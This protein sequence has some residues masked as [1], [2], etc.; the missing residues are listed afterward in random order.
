MIKSRGIT[1]MC[2][3]LLL[4]AVSVPA[5]A[6]NSAVEELTR[7]MPDQTMLFVATSGHDALADDCAKTILG[8]LC[9]DP[10]VQTFV[11]T[12]KTELL[13][14]LGR[15]E[16]EEAPEVVNMILQYAEL[17]STRPIMI[18]LAGVEVEEGPPACLFVVLEAGPRKAEIAAAL[19]KLEAM[20]QE[21]EA[22][23]DTQVGSLTLH[24]LEEAGGLP[25]YW[26]W[27]GDRLVLAAN[28]P[29]GMAMKYIQSPRSAPT[30]HLKKVPGYGD[31]LAVHLDVAKFW[32]TVQ[33][34]ANAEGG[35]EDIKPVKAALD[36]LGISQVGTIVGRV[37]ISG[38]EVISD[39]FAAVPEP[40][41]GL[42][43]AFKPA[44]PSLFRRVDAQAVTASALNVDLAH[45]FDTAMATLKAIS[46]EEG[47]P[48]VTKGL[49]QMESELGFKVRDGLI[50]SLGGPAVV[51]TLPAGKMVEA[52]MGGGILLAKLNDPALFEQTMTQIG[53]VAAKMSEGMLQ[54]S[55]QTDTDGRKTHVWSVGPLAMA[56]VLPT[57]S[58]VDDYLV[59]GSNTPLCAMGVKQATA[60]GAEAKSLLDAPGYKKV[61][62]KLPDNLLSIAYIDSEVQFNQM[63]M[64]LQQFWP[65]AAMAAMQAKIK[66]PVMLP[67]LG[68]IAQEMQPSIEYSY[69]RPDGFYS[70]YQ[71]TG[72]EVGLRS[73]VAPAV[74]AGVL[75][76][77]LARSR[78]QARRV[79]AMSNLKQLG[80]AVIMYADEN[81]GTFPP[82]LATAKP[83]YGDDRVLT[84]PRKPVD[85]AGPSYIYI[86]G[87]SMKTE[88]PYENIMIY[89]NPEICDDGTNVVFCD[90]H[91][92][93]M[94]PWEFREALERTYERLGKEAPE[95]HFRGE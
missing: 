36:Q 61:A 52:P 33:A 84:S 66:L 29:K 82:D 73:L 63:M 28:D 95:V 45:I 17:A 56:Q 1:M 46:P 53:T 25:L 21:E 5:L 58:I 23:V 6:A 14:A 32:N 31:I 80:L 13:A 90:G 3:T 47:Y 24:T 74:G 85:F 68:H 22:I 93:F 78:T 27:L 12:I 48:E 49:A 15:E 18:G 67:S 70:H 92:E 7:V 76:P 30:D 69:A 75:M 65:M 43:A 44:D 16:G 35:A 39:S 88:R 42:M 62:E 64:Q 79:A 41:T 72:V 54:I 10:G 19:T 9:T 38:S 87:H 57:W 50:K 40:R 34:F 81:D 11:Q 60:Q 55:S 71:G 94:H 4:A 26:G 86:P 2:V 89:E 77:A 83:Y 37:G 20:I 59:L 91:V 8:R 51:Y